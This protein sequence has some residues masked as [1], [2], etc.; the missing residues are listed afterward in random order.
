M[1]MAVGSCLT[2]SCSLAIASWSNVSC[3][4][5]R[6]ESRIATDS[7]SCTASANSSS[8]LNASACPCM[9]S[10]R[11]SLKSSLTPVPRSSRMTRQVELMICFCSSASSSACCPFWLCCCCC[12]CC[13]CCW[14]P[15][16][17]SPARKI[18]S[19]GLTSAKNMSL[20]VRRGCP[21]GPVSS[22][23]K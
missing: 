17:C 13:C 18:S 1:P 19:K 11:L 22:A 20:S 12:C 21:S 10:C 9:M 16:G 14:P 7:S 15:G 4:S 8:W 6:T 5:L 3:M 23:Q 2:S